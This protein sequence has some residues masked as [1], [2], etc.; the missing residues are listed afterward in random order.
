MFAVHSRFA[1]KRRLRE[2]DSLRGIA[3]VCVLLFH[4][5]YHTDPYRQFPIQFPWGHYGVELFFVISG[6]VIL[7][8]LERSASRTE[9]VISRVT[10]LYPTYWC[11]VLF[12]T[13]VLA[14]LA[15]TR[16]LFSADAAAEYSR[17][18]GCECRTRG[19]SR[20]NCRRCHNTRKLRRSPPNNL[21]AHITNSNRG[22]PVYCVAFASY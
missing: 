14:L 19:S 1:D 17:A 2:L 18:L 9:F 8:T 7:M 22:L 4:L 13:C 16:G 15:K 12:T 20:S 21:P 10:R 5:S 11:A 3:A 6:F